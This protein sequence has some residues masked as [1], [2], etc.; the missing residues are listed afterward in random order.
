[1][2]LHTCDQRSPEWHTLRLGIP[3]ASEFSRLVTSK[4]APSTSLSGYAMELAS[5]LFAGR[6][7]DAFDG[8]VWMERGAE[9]EAEAIRLYEFTTD[10]TVTP[11]GFITNDA[12]TAGC[13]P[14]GLVGD[15]GML[16]IKCPKAERFMEAV[17][18]HKKNGRA[19]SGYAQQTQGQLLLAERKWVDML[20]YHPDLP[21][22][23]IRQQPDHAMFAALAIGIRDVIAERDVALATLRNQGD[24]A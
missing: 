22:L 2:I 12:G 19:P 11:C 18:Y 21:P 6:P 1:M 5:E 10:R 8:N 20:F 24:A 3:T 17:V 14:D 9:L 23:I 15:D 16:E 13:S 4:G 7:L